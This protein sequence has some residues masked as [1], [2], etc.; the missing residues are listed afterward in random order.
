MRIV[1]TGSTGFIG[2]ALVRALVGRGDD[3]VC[4]IRP[5][6]T[7]RRSEVSNNVRE[8]NPSA[9]VLNP[10]D[11]N[12]SDAV[13]HLAG[14]GI[15]ERKWTPTQKQRIVESRTTSTALLA[16]TIAGVPEPP[17]LFLSGSAIGYYGDTGQIAVD[18]HVAPGHD[19]T[20]QVCVA[21]E[22]AAGPAAEAGITTTFL[23]TGLVLAAHG[24]VLKRMLLPF[25][26]G[27]GGRSG[28]GNQWMSW[29]SLR[30]EVAAIIHLIDTPI[31]GP[32]NLT[33]PEPVTNRDFVS[34]LGHAL[35]RPTIL[36]TPRLPLYA[37]F[38]KELVD[39]L[40]FASQ[41]VLPSAL[42]ES[43]FQFRDTT[44]QECFANLSDAAS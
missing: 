14:E 34:A 37:K 10:D 16:N 38:G 19:F 42:L 44:I 25:R 40:M 32:V 27:L 3:V 24:G 6:T 18:E 4:L 7:S 35:H 36:P 11:V 29:I 20:A 21:W 31:D 13:I 15:G 33:A 41:R 39:T 8:W 12:G 22:H 1:V 9:G 28:S 17:A 30:D 5:A 23:R 2:T 26:L 43:G